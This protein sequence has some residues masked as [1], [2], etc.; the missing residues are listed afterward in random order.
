MCSL[1]QYLVGKLEEAEEAIRALKV[2]VEESE[3]EESAFEDDD[4][5][6]KDVGEDEWEVVTR[7]HGKGAWRRLSVEGGRTPWVDGATERARHRTRA[8]VTCEI[9]SLSNFIAT[10]SGFLS[11]LRAELPSLPSPSA[12]AS[13]VQFQLSPDA[14][15]ALDDFLSSHARPYFPQLDLRARLDG[16]KSLATN[17]AN[18]L[19]CYVSCELSGLQDVFIHLKNSSLLAASDPLS[20][21]ISSFPSLPPLPTPPLQ[22]ISSL[23]SYFRAESDKLHASLPSPA[24]LTANL[25][26]LGTE[27]L[28]AIRDEAH[29]LTSLLTSHSAAAIDEAARLYHAA[30]ERGRKR[31]LRY[32]E[33]PHEWRNNE[34]ILSGYRFISSESW[35]T[36]LRSGFEFH[37]ETIKCGVLS[38][39]APLSPRR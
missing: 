8:E 24:G 1:R 3:S 29:E 12:S 28:N 25:V 19:L 11:A 9:S 23:R 33:L 4:A 35:G 7:K 30:V 18:A 10:A 6:D 27:G 5:D 15:L 14:R 13:L 38:L 37:N 36:L 20:S 16:S 26:A 21:Y 17:K 31:L 22:P 34:H 32:E 2:Y 39:S